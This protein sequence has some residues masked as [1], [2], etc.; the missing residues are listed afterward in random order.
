MTPENWPTKRMSVVSLHLDSKNPRLGRE[1]AQSAPRE[2]VQ[3]L[4]E[5]Y[6]AFDVAQS[7][8]ERGF[9]PN[10]ALLAYKEGNT[11]IVVEG[12]RR[13]AAL[14]AL[15]EPG[16]LEGAMRN[17]VERLARAIEHPERIAKV[18]VTIAPSRRAT[19]GQLV[20]RHMGKP[21]QQWEAEN[22]AS[23]ILDKLA[24][25]YTNEK[26]SDE[27]GFS[28]SDIQKAR[29]T[30]AIADMAR[31][32]PLPEEVA[33][34]LSNPRAKVFS[35]L[36]RVFDSAVGRKHLNVQPSAEHG[37]KGT[38]TKTEFKRV[39]TRL[40]SDVALGN[41]SSRTLNT[42]ENIDDYFKSW[43]AGERPKK[44][45]GKF[46]PSDLIQ[47][48]SVASP[49]ERPK[50]PTKRA[51]SGREGKTVLPKSLKVRHGETRIRDIHRELTK[52]KRDDFPNAGA[53]LLRVFFELVA[54][55]YLKRTGEYTPLVNKLGGKRKLAHGVPTMKQL[56]PSLAGRAK[57]V[58]SKQEAN[59]VEK[60]ITPN[61][62]APFSISEL[63]SFVHNP[64]DIPCGRD[65]LQFWERTEP[66]FR[67][68]L[69]E[70]VEKSEQ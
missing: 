63:H 6:K 34:K 37:L 31:S 30:R 46:V 61:P 39:F 38:T 12:N 28:L 13:L 52:L 17:K 42:N 16:L 43:P 51:G 66:L 57:K 19:D 53:V 21:V 23:F 9:F 26:L 25:G 5:H 14:K 40:V 27:L 60:A 24:E 50:P 41:A 7:I 4:F 47:G 62:K 59:T 2:I 56:T 68:M 69:E 64:N 67:M 54:I 65:L 3:H 10:E 70:D 48:K 58:L 45:R 1:A 11:Y 33:A 35:T 49:K 15:R 44:K 20:A 8:A 22:R 32:L 18:P 55:D 36:G 29:Q